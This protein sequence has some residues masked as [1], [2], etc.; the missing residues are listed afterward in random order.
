[1]APIIA[2]E[3]PPK[4]VQV[5]FSRIMESSRPQLTVVCLEGC[6]GSGKTVICNEMRARGYPVL[7]EAFLDMPS[8]SLDPQSLLMETY[9]VCNWFQSILRLENRLCLASARKNHTVFVDRSPYSAVFYARKGHLL[10]PLIQEQMQEIQNLRRIQFYTVH[11]TVNPELLWRRICARLEREPERMRLHEADR[12]WMHQILDIY[13]A[14]SWDFEI[15][16][17]TSNLQTI[18]I[19][20]LHRLG[21]HDTNVDIGC[22]EKTTLITSNLWSMDSDADTHESEFDIDED[23][24]SVHA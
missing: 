19:E 23:L 20:I 7:D 22:D 24:S 3:F 8:Y 4:M 16:N 6:H 21:I 18:V 14:F 5:D 13:A 10:Q 12:A 1:M 2:K 11:I 9:W 17:D 15:Q